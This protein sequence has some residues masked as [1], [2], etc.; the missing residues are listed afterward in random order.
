LFLEKKEWIFSS[1]YALDRT[2]QIE[3]KIAA[4]KDI[5]WGWNSRTQNSRSESKQNVV[6][7]ETDEQTKK[8]ESQARSS[9]HTKKAM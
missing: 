5:S 6:K 1:R 7:R 3:N 4:Y 8:T 2:Q 9:S